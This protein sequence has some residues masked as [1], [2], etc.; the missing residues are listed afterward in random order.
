MWIEAAIAYR[1]GIASSAEQFNLA[2]R[3]GLGYTADRTWLGFFDSLG[4]GAI[5]DAIAR[6]SPLTACMRAPDG[7]VEL[8]QRTSP[9]AALQQFART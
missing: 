9:M 2:M 7:L 4:S 5:V 1:E 3:G 6:W 8:L